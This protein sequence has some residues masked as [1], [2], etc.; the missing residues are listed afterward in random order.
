MKILFVILV[1]FSGM[2]LGGCVT[3]SEPITMTFEKTTVRISA[4]RQKL[5][6]GDKVYCRTGTEGTN[7]YFG[8]CPVA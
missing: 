2:G 5:F 8:P 6:V 4:D 3:K 7:I 1:L